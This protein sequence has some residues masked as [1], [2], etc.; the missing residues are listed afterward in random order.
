M[1]VMRV[2]IFAAEHNS[3]ARFAR[4]APVAR[5]RNSMATVRAR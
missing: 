4:R 5:R 3:L 1:G 2:A